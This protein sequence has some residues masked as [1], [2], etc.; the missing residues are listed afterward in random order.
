[1]RNSIF[2][3]SILLVAIGLS[4]PSPAQERRVPAHNPEWTDH[5]VHDPGIPSSPDEHEPAVESVSADLQRIVVLCATHPNSGEFER[6]WRDYVAARRGVGFDLDGTI[7][8][9]LRRAEQ[10]RMFGDGIRGARLPTRSLDKAELRARM[11]RIA[12]EVLGR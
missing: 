3:V 9:V 7:G 8:T 12:R 10:R 4:V 2:L 5:N 1:M 11:T 6:A